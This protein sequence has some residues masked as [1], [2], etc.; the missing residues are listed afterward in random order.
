MRLSFMVAM[1]VAVAVLMPQSGSAQTATPKLISVDPGS[2]KAGD[3]LSV[4]GENLE[5]SMVV[6]LYLTDGKNDIKVPITEQSEKAIK[7]TVPPG[8]EAGALQPDGF[9]RR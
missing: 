6:E 5:K 9:D 3:A 1:L 2:A 8:G 7:F 4:T